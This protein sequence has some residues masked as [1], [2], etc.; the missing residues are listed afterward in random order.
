MGSSTLAKPYV[1]FYSNI[2]IPA[3]SIYTE[4]IYLVYTGPT[5]VYKEGDPT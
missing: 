3:F 2:L 5:V 1:Q 4:T